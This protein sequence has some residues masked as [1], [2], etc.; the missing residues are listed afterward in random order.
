MARIE[1]TGVRMDAAVLS[2]ISALG[3]TI[4]GAISSLGSTWMTT[5]AQARAA[6]VAA[7]RGKRE[8]LY[9]RFMDQLSKLYAGALQSTGVD[10]DRLSECYAIAGRIQ[11]YASQPVAEAAK[12]ALRYILDIAIG[13]Q[14]SDAETRA[15]MDREGADVIGDFAS[16]CRAELIAL[17]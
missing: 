7:E 5:R 13:P 4:V 8:E 12:T 3:G 15:L 1:L 9:G 14:R 10:Y 6:R 16:A 17:R 11:L 2:T